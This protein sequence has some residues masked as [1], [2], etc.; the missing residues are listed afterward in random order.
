MKISELLN[1]SFLGPNSNK[2]YKLLNDAYSIGPFDG[3]CVIFARAL[4]IKFGGDIIVLCN[5]NIAHHAALHLSGGDLIDADGKGS[6]ED[7]I[8]RFENNEGV[9]I[10]NIRA[11][12]DADLPDAPRDEK[13]SAQIAE[14]LR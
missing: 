9:S 3:G 2:I 1:E 10:T 11:L 12:T 8:D 13:L 14:L 7:V 5:R 6:A 4:Q